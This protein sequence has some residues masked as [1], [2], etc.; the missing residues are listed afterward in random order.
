[1]EL[2]GLDAGSLD[3]VWFGWSDLRPVPSDTKLKQRRN[4]FGNI[5]GSGLKS[6]R[7][8][9]LISRALRSNQINSMI[10]T[11]TSI[12]RL[13]CEMRNVRLPSLLSLLCSAVVCC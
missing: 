11:C 4:S 1:V 7:P 13:E 2:I 9:N 5:F 6:S 3:M 8:G 12:D 10:P